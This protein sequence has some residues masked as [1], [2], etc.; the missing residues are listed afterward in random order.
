MF[1][2]NFTTDEF[3]GIIQEGAKARLSDEEF[4]VCEIQRFLASKRRKEMLDGIRYYKG[5]HDILRHTRKIIGE[6][7]EL[8]PAENLVNNRVIDNQYKKMVSQKNNYLVGQPITFT[9]E[10][11]LYNDALSRVFSK[12]FLRKIKNVGRD[13]LN[14]GIG[15]L[16][17][18]Y[19]EDGKLSFRRMRPFEIIP[20]WHDEEHTVLDYAIRI[21][22]TIVFEGRTEKTVQKVEVYHETGINRFILDGSRLRTDEVPHSPY[23][24]VTVDDE[25]AYN[26]LLI[27]L[28]PFKYNDD[29][30]PLIRNVK[31]LQ[32]GINSILSNFQNNIDEDPRN[33]ILVLINYD[34]E[35][36]AEFRRNLSA[37]GAVK[38]TTVDGAHGD[39]KT[40]AVEV[41]AEN[42]RTI[43]EIFRKAIIENAMGYDAKDDKLGGNANQLNIMSMYN[44]IDMDA[45]ETETEYQASFEQLLHFVD[46]HL[47]NTGEGDFESES[48]EAIFNRDM[49]ISETEIV[50]NI[51]NSEGILSKETLVA[52]HPFTTDP[53][54]ELERIEKEKAEAMAD[55]GGDMFARPQ[56]S[57]HQTPGGEM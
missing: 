52:N 40:L 24:T 51:R 50:N 27:P 31:S 17:L 4:I 34:G 23:F 3:V 11:K 53:A 13:S 26:W 20:G 15:W 8:I 32:D 42:Y 14:C 57:H 1:R 54:V 49:L 29:E 48:V 55:F 39:L 28:I 19:S 56:L 38:L 9:A 37:Y 41:N 47:A 36:L 16:F 44:D 35:N 33:S 46:L 18:Y 12:N 6:K 2:F 10:N 45:N 5:D 43:L 7:G 22:E 21:F 25:A 30:I